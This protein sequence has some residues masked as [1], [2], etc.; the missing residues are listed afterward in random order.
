MVSSAVVT[1]EA[2]EVKEV[3]AR[4]LVE[5]L[6]IGAVAEEAEVTEAAIAEV[7]GAAAE[8]EHAAVLVTVEHRKR[9]SPAILCREACR[10]LCAPQQLSYSSSS[11]LRWQ[12]GCPCMQSLKS[13]SRLAA[14]DPA[15][16]TEPID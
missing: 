2:D 13:T 14:T 3:E 10:I 11:T 15:M 7:T 8:G 16:A 4:I 6:E 12:C 5:V 1:V 9:L